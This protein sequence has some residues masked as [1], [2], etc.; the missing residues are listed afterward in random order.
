M[1]FKCPSCD[2]VAV[3]AGALATHKKAH[4][5][6]FQ[7]CNYC[8]FRSDIKSYFMFGK[9]NYHRCK[10]GDAARDEARASKAAMTYECPSCDFVASNGS[11]LSNHT[12]GHSGQFQSCNYCSFRSD[13][14]AHFIQTGK[15][16][17]HRC[18]GGDA[19]NNEGCI[20]QHVFS[21]SMSSRLS[22]L[23][24]PRPTSIL[25]P[26]PSVL[27]SNLFHSLLP[28][29]LPVPCPLP[30]RYTTLPRTASHCVLPLTG[31]LK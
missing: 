9:R 5:G 6:Q 24:H 13:I 14:K 2:Y 23:P 26:N 7:S 21:S 10:G 8:S 3:N 22:I 27:C 29:S 12:R 11:A 4:S 31:L 17:F 19:A 1:T 30:L 20:S 18:K 16:N 25:L 28:F 15:S